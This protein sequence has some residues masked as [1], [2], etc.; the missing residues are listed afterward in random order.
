MT[1]SVMTE[2]VTLGEFLRA[3]RGTRSTL[4]VTRAG[5]PSSGNI[6]HYETGNRLPSVPTLKWLCD[7]YGIAFDDALQLLQ[8][9][10][11]KRDIE[12]MQAAAVDTL[13]S[14]AG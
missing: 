14:V 13:T 10:R 2:R 11:T 7:H 3:S 1:G 12:A 9:A 8:E 4:D 6:S 5:G